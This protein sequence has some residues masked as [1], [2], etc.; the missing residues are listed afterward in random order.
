MLSIIFEFIGGPHDGKLATGGLG[1]AG[2]AERY[3][4]F[5]N[6]GVIGYLFKVAS[7]YAVETIAREGLE[8]HR[9]YHFQ[10]HFYIV[11]DRL[12]EDEEVYVRAQYIPDRGVH[13]Q[14][15]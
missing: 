2:D 4:L 9:R 14:A 8:A 15:G 10:K 6:H 11:T 13:S 12:E 5:T 1:E 7:E 3:Y